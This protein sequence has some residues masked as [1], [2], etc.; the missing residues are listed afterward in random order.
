MLANREI[1]KRQTWNGKTR[2]DSEQCLTVFWLHHLP[3]PSIGK[4]TTAQSNTPARQLSKS[5]VLKW[6]STHTP[7][8]STLVTRLVHTGCRFPNRR[9]AAP[10]SCAL[11]GRPGGGCGW[12]V[13]TSHVSLCP[14]TELVAARPRLLQNKPAR[15]RWCSNS[16]QEPPGGSICCPH[17][18][19]L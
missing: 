13:R 7:T 1:P 15:R 8:P 3:L 16:S 2:L 6:V 10:V 9:A 11:A 12:E 14:E 4:S 18:A 17:C 19:S 5:L